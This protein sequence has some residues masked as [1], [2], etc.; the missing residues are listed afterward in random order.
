MAKKKAIEKAARKVPPGAQSRTEWIPSPAQANLLEVAS[1]AGLHR[2][3]TEVCKAAR[4]P[5]RTFYDWLRYDANF[6][7]AWG[8]LWRLQIEHHLPGVT[9]AT[10]HQAQRGDVGAARTIMEVAKILKHQ[11]EH[12]GNIG[13]AELVAKPPKVAP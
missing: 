1:Q 13:L 9:A 3:L 5:R 7:S 6:K 2:N 10:I 4:V 8:N 12:S 11:M